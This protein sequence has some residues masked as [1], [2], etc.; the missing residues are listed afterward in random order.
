MRETSAGTS[1]SILT[2]TTTNAV[3]PTSPSLSQSPAGTSRIILTPTTTNTISSYPLINGGSISS[4]MS[5]AGQS[6]DDILIYGN[7]FFAPLSLSTTPS[8]TGIKTASSVIPDASLAAKD[9]NLLINPS[10]SPANPL[11]TNS[12]TGVTTTKLL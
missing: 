9:K 12:L 5:F 3:T 10:T 4:M 1:A 7:G 6:D 11:T 2:A 8:T